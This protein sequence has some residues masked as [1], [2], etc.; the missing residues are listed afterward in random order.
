LTREATAQP[1]EICPRWLDMRQASK[2]CS[3]HRQ[4]LV[5]HVLAGEIY[6]TQKGGKWYVDRLSIDAWMSADTIEVARCLGKGV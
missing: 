4:T 3:M 2:Y 6:G 1:I 5:R